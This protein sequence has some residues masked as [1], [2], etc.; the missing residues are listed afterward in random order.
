METKQCRDCTKVLPLDMFGKSGKYYR[1]YCRPCANDRAR[2]YSVKYRDKRNA[3]LRRR[4]ALNLESNRARERRNRIKYLYGLSLEEVETMRTAQDGRCLLCL[5]TSEKLAIDHCHATGKV[6]GLLC[7]RCNSFLGDVEADPTILERF[8]L[9]LSD[10]LA[11]LIH[12]A[13]R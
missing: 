13:P 7:P 1:S 2:V 10:D 8:T 6:R 11:S 4:R 9:Y 12:T 5:R 3:R